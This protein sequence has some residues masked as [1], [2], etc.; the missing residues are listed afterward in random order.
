MA[1]VVLRCL[2]MPIKRAMPQAGLRGKSNGGVKTPRST[3]DTKN[4]IVRYYFVD[5][6]REGAVGESV[7]KLR[8]RVRVRVNIRVRVSVQI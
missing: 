2:P 5:S 3:Y 6:P 4:R 8:M 1:L 7:G